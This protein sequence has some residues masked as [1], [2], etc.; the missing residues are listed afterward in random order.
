ML[1]WSANTR[2]GENWIQI[3]TGYKAK[4]QWSPQ[5]GDLFPNFAADSTHGRLTFHSWAGNDWIY[6]FSHPA[7]FRGVC[8]TELASL[9][10]AFRDARKMGLRIIGLTRAPLPEIGRWIDEVE[11]VFD[12]SVD[13]P[14]ISDAEGRLARS[15]G[16]IHEREN[17]ALTMR[18]SF[19]IDPSL[20]VRLMFDYPAMVGRSTEE[21]LRTVAALQASDR[22]RL[23]TPADWQ[24]GDYLVAP[25]GITDDDMDRS[26]GV[27]W[28]PVL[29]YIRVVHPRAVSGAA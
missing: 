27:G 6:F 19:I 10:S 16:L 20:R 24:P 12:L 25:P 28:S 2:D 23:A 26:F 11:Q 29:D 9:A 15:F 22:T 18:K 13:F 14:V 4:R 3:P 1:M 8:S 7:P 17:P 5:I 21:V